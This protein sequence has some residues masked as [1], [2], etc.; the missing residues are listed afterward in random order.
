[1]IDT[2]KILREN[3]ERMKDEAANYQSTVNDLRVQIDVLDAYLKDHIE[4][5]SDDYVIT[6]TPPRDELGKQ[7]VIGLFLFPPLLIK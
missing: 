3:K 4:P 2:G 6:E 5:V 1:L 7:C